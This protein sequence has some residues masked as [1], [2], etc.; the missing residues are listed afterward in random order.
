MSQTLHI[1]FNMPPQCLLSTACL[2]YRNI[3][4]TTTIPI[5][6]SAQRAEAHLEM[7]VCHHR[8]FLHYHNALTDPQHIIDAWHHAQASGDLLGTDANIRM[9]RRS[10]DIS[11]SISRHCNVTADT[12]QSEIDALASRY[13]SA[14][15]SSPATA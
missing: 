15:K 6:P 1:S 11:P 2:I 10:A 9:M 5:D 12:A 4:T 3:A 14:C 13:R 8:K 7:F